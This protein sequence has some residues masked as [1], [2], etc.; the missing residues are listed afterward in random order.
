MLDIQERVVYLPRS[1]SGR[2]VISQSDCAFGLACSLFVSSVPH[3]KLTPI[4]NSGPWSSPQEESR[5][6]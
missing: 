2:K 4:F 6:D 5:S 1:V 3:L